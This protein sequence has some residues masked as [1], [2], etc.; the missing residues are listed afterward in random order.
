MAD[1][2]EDNQTTGNEGT[3]TT[4]AIGYNANG[5]SEVQ[6]AEYEAYYA[7]KEEYHP[8]QPIHK[9]SRHFGI[10]QEDNPFLVS[11]A[12]DNWREDMVLGELNINCEY[13]NWIP[14]GT[15]TSRGTQQKLFHSNSTQN[16]SLVYHLSKANLIKLK[17]ETGHLLGCDQE[18]FMKVLM[19]KV[20]HLNVIAIIE[21]HE[22]AYYHLA[23]AHVSTSGAFSTNAI[24]P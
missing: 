15:T 1:A 21:C 19:K 5:L 4:V 11:E 10:V 20:L 13:N 18:D 14:Q 16:V 7:R 22:T 12:N 23:F 2:T 8:D 3:D 9:D 24:T 17:S 6:Q